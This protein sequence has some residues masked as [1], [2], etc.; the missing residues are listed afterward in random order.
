[1][2]IIAS[3]RKLRQA[4]NWRSSPLAAIRIATPRAL[5]VPSAPEIGRLTRTCMDTEHRG[6]RLPD[7]VLAFSNAEAPEKK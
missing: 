1:M 5:S 6:Q 3:Y 7:S 2:R 4:L